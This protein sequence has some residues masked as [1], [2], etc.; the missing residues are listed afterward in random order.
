MR[1]LALVGPGTRPA[2][3]SLPSPRESAGCQSGNANANEAKPVVPEVPPDLRTILRSHVAE[4]ALKSSSLM[5]FAARKTENR[6]VVMQTPLEA[7]NIQ[8][9]RTFTHTEIVDV[10]AAAQ[11]LRDDMP[12]NKA[13]ITGSRKTVWPSLCAAM[14]MWH[15]RLVM[16][17][18]EILHIE[19]PGWKRHEELYMHSMLGI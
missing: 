19:Q 11:L 13:T 18:A 4:F 1:G 5:L 12:T 2:S 10:N 3:G 17:R 9:Y 8:N 6:H 14:H 16:D 7:F 15:E